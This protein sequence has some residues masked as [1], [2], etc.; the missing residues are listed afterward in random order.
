MNQLDQV[1]TVSALRWMLLAQ[2]LSLGMH[3]IRMPYGLMALLG[4]CLIWR[5]QIIRGRWRFPNNSVKVMLATT[6]L[7]VLVLSFH[8]LSVMAAVS[9]LLLA[10][11]LKL[12]EL[13]T[14]RDAFISLFLS[15]LVVAVV[16]LFD[17][18]LSTASL[19]FVV[20]VIITCALIAMHSIKERSTVELVRQSSL[21]WLS[22][23][24]LMI[25]F[26]V[27]FPR[28]APLWSLDLGSGAK[29]GLS[30]NIS[31]GDIARL[32]QS[33]ELVFRAKF[34]Q[35]LPI[36]PEQLYWRAFVLDKTDGRGWQRSKGVDYIGNHIDW[37]GDP[38][39]NWQQHMSIQGPFY[40]YD[41]ILEPTQQRWL[42]SLD[43]SLPQ[44]RN[45]G[46]TQDFMLE[47]NKPI[48]QVLRY[49]SQLPAQVIREP[50]LARWRTAR[51]LQLPENENPRTKA[52][53]QQFWQKT[54]DVEGFI[55]TAL[56]YFVENQFS[57]TLK[58][59]VLGEKANDEFLFETR[60]GF[61]GHY[62]GALALLARYAGIPARV[63]AGYLGGEW[64]NAANYLTV[65]QYDAHAWAEIWVPQKGWV[66]V[67]PTSVIAPDRVELGLAEAM[68][69]E[70]SFLEN[71]LFSPHRYQGLAVMD[72]IRKFV[73]N[74]NYQ[75]SLR[76]VGFDVN[77]QAGIFS[78]LIKQWGRYSW[79]L[80][81]G[82][83]LLALA[84]PLILWGG[85]QLIK[86]LRRKR[87]IK[88]KFEDK[89][90]NTIIK[91]SN[92]ANAYG[93][94]KSDVRHW[95]PREMFEHLRTSFP[96]QSQQ[97]G[98]L[99]MRYEELCYGDMASLGEED[100]LNQWRFMYKQLKQ[101]EIK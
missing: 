3:L 37:Y 93:L 83:I 101:L 53:A 50:R 49:R 8:K 92:Y 52:L 56:A 72:S 38:V 98:W 34:D 62:A 76:V 67:D 91:K 16:F 9:F 82:F 4:L 66:K 32:T 70:G 71:S 45:V 99:S 46:L 22:A 54:G 25:I 60:K 74:I 86:G 96:E 14:Q 17:T 81:G 55:S 75:W 95:T 59:P 18:S 44:Q 43:G 5:F 27:F 64:N 51:E 30:D 15:Y 68:R 48:R 1:L 85:F 41:V 13:H 23:I 40:P 65:R 73:D 87:T 97:I 39:S 12:I 24:P 90:V 28:M 100:S 78:D 58:P 20:C 84:L 35:G 94:I 11:G 2:A 63:V 36:P 61:C 31:P 33:D 21:Y 57:Y 69:E 7:I 47:Y 19:A 80:I 77:K 42:Y 89:L 88:Q 26:F 79:L 29:T 10:Y 6:G